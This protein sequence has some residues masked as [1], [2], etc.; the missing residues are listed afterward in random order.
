MYLKKIIIL[1]VQM[2]TNWHTYRKYLL[3]FS[4]V[5][6][7]IIWCRN[8]LFD[9]SIL[10]SKSYF[11]PTINVGNIAVGGTGKTP[12]IEYLINL[13]SNDYKV[14]TLS[15]GY[16]RKTK[17]FLIA[18]PKHSFE[19]IGDEPKQLKYQFKDVI[20]TV[21]GNRQRGIE[22]LEKLEEKPDLIL[23]DDAFQHRYVRPGVNI[24]LTDY[25]KP[26]WE[27][28]ILPA[29]DLRDSS[30]QV[31]RADIV[32]VSKSPV[33]ITA[34]RKRIILRNLNLFP[35]QNLF[36]T[37]IVYGDLICIT[38]QANYIKEDTAVLMLT[39][40]AN[41]KHLETHLLRNYKSVISLEFPDHHS[42]T[43]RDFVNVIEQYNLISSEN[44][45]IV[46][47]L[48]DAVRLKD[49]RNFTKFSEIPMFYQSMKIEFLE[50]EKEEFNKL[51]LKYVRNAKR[52]R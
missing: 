24:L 21:D 38:K 49:N 26:Y 46:T 10:K 5:Y 29:G 18:D 16:K 8:W 48:K 30:E 34:M 4:L 1:E 14:A 15:R 31:R 23:L 22:Q 32:I 37:T 9:V 44:K 50:G 11:T 27:D 19:D 45:I 25:S 52:D 41:P 33:L 2:N 6:G 13:L 42:F 51:I 43:E 36:F 28:K 3:P 17:G 7:F 12:H 35:Y 47:T 20:V 40:I 39:G